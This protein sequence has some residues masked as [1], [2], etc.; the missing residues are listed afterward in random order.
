MPELFLKLVAHFGTQQLTATAL[1]VDQSTVSGWCRGC[2]GMSPATAI[3]AEEVTE[4]A[5]SRRDLCPDFP[6]GPAEQIG[7]DLGAN[8]S[9]RSDPVVGGQ[10]C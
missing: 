7:R 3:R 2:W 6:W 8:D 4:G 10:S 1:K 9:R 5:F